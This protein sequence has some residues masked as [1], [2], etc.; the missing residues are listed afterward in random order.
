MCGQKFAIYHVSFANTY[1][2]NAALGRM[3]ARAA[4]NRFRDRKFDFEDLIDWDSSKS[5]KAMIFE[6]AGFAFSS[7]DTKPF[8]NGE[9]DPLLRKEQ[10]F[11]RIFRDVAAPYWIIAAAAGDDETLRHEFVHCV[12]MA[13]PD[14]RAEVREFLS[15][16]KL[17]TARKRLCAMGYSRR[18]HLDELNAY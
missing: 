3:Y 4:S 17:K 16:L 2:L 7:E 14:Y 9:M 18:N 11:L 12:Y 10:A 8:L 15:T 1:V 6:W 13:F 5:E